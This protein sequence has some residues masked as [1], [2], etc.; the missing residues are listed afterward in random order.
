LENNEWCFQPRRISNANSSL[1]QRGV[2][3]LGEIKEYP[4]PPHLNPLMDHQP[5]FL[6]AESP[7]AFYQSDHLVGGCEV[8]SL[9]Q[10]SLEVSLKELALPAVPV[11]ER[12]IPA[13]GLGLRRH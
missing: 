3:L 6:V 11:L 10:G 12:Q 5:G 8:Q 9:G 1:P 4:A 2:L 13:V 7:C